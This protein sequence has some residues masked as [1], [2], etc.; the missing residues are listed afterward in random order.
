MSVA[1]LV[2][3][4]SLRALPRKRLSWLL[5]RLS[6]VEGAD[7]LLKAAIRVYSH[8]YGVDLTDYE[9]PPGGFAS[10]DDF[11]TRKVKPEARPIAGDA[12]CVVAPSDGRLDDAGPIEAGATFRVKGRH[13]ELAELLGDSGAVADFEGGWFAVIYL[14]PGDYHRVHAPVTGDVHALR[15][16]AGTLFP[17]NALGVQY[18]PRL[19][20]RNERVVVHQRSERFGRVAT[21]LVGAIGVGRMS[22]SFDESIITNDGRAAGLRVYGDRAVRLERGAE[23]GVFHMGSTVVLLMPAAAKLVFQVA[24]GQKV[25]MGEVLAKR[26]E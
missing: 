7:P 2:V 6:R 24:P 10:F 3:S 20:A 16:I 4:T 26:G 21:I 17:V 23:L 25:R 22:V 8:A 5:G 19:L 15:H 1:S 9:I 18:V 11:F 14:A 13:Y 12:N